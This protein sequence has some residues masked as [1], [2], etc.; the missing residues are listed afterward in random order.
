MPHTQLSIWRFLPHLTAGNNRLEDSSSNKDNSNQV[1]EEDSEDVAEE[2]NRAVKAKAEVRAIRARKR[3]N[4]ASRVRSARATTAG[5]QG[6]LPKI[7]GV[8]PSNRQRVNTVEHVADEEDVLVAVEDEDTRPGQQ[9]WC[10]WRSFRRSS[11]SR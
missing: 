11:H 4:Q 5:N 10:P 2:D 9:P 8:P 3:V 6:I 1:D 7:A